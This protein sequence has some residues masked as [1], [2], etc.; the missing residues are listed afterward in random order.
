MEA[1]AVVGVAAA[2]LQFLDFGVRALVLC[3]QIRDKGSTEAN[4]K[5]E[6]HTEEV[7][8]IYNELQQDIA[9]PAAN[10]QITRTRQECVSVGDELLSL[11]NNVKIS[12]RSKNLAAVKATFHDM[13]GKREIEKIQNKLEDSQKRFL[14]AVGV[15]TLKSVVRLMEEQGKSNEDVRN[16]LIPEARQGRAESSKNHLKTQEGASELKRLSSTA[17][18]KTQSQLRDIQ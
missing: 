13:K 10:R 17:H 5:L 18:Y 8:K 16:V 6:H 1:V 12:S 3:K 2:A 11:L 9:L 15:E 7:Q 14:A 4:Q